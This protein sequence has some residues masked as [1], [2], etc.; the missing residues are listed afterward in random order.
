MPESGTGVGSL[1]AELLGAIDGLRNNA[2][3]RPRV[4]LTENAK[5]GRLVQESLSALQGL[6]DSLGDY[7][8]RVLPALEPRISRDAVRAFILEIRREL[9]ELAA[10]HTAG[11]VYVEELTVTESVDRAVSLEV[12]GW[13]G[14]AG[15]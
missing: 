13:L 5:A 11:D 6:S 3:L 7:L 8:E 12:E 2:N 15:L 10:C 9:D 1:H 4:T 14:A